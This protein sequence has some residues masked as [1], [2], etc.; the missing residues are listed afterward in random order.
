M[1][2]QCDEYPFASTKQGASYAQGNCS[3]KALNGVQNRKHPGDGTKCGTMNG[4]TPHHRE[5]AAALRLLPVGDRDKDAEILA[6]APP[7]HR[8]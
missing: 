3:L 2:N 7:D 6:P 1:G 5:H 8:P 4:R